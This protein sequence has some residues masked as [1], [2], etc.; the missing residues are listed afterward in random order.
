VAG[1][2]TQIRPVWIGELENRPKTSK[3][4]WFWPFIFIFI[5]EI[6]FLAISAT[7]FKTVQRCRRQH[8]KML[9]AVGSGTKNVQALSLTVLSTTVVNKFKHCR[10]QH[11]NAFNAVADS[12]DNFLRRRR[13]RLKCLSFGPSSLVTNPYR[14]DLCKTLEPNI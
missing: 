11:L 10:Q 4:F 13:Q 5:G 3:K 7:A 1:I 8:L 14:P 2:F 9:C 12:T 6:V